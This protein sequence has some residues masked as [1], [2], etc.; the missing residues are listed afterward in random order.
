LL[1]RLSAELIQLPREQWRRHL[2][3]LPMRA[4]R[5]RARR[6]GG[7]ANTGR[8]AVAMNTRLELVFHSSPARYHG[9]I[10]LFAAEDSIHK[11]FLD[12]RIYWS[13]AASE[14]LELHLLPGSH[15]L[16]CQEPLLPGFAGVLESCLARARRATEA[17]LADVAG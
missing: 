7:P 5:R 17:S 10:T 12:R 1:E 4:L 14:G 6:Q 8:A 15:N 16:M 11:G 9:R 13:R 3:D 2:I